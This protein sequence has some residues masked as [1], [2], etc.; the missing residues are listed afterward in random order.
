MQP[1]GRPRAPVLPA[2]DC[3][4]GA[5]AAPRAAPQLERAREAEEYDF[6]TRRPRAPRRRVHDHQPG[7][8][9]ESAPLSPPA[10]TVGALRRLVQQV[11]AETAHGA[12]VPSVPVQ[13]SAVE[14]DD[15]G[16]VLAAGHAPRAAVDAG[17]DHAL[18]DERLE[19]LDASPMNSDRR[20]HEEMLVDAF[21]LRRPRW[22]QHH[23]SVQH[24]AQL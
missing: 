19:A 24:Y 4:A 8:E 15:Y 14:V 2:A 3:A 6:Q 9:G 11:R 22:R 17:G 7:D 1:R 23:S 13:D 12:I 5:A 21:T 20:I 18:A 16:Y 10:A